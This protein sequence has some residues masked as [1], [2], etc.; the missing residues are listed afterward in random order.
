MDPTWGQAKGG[1]LG[2]LVTSTQPLEGLKVQRGEVLPASFESCSMTPINSGSS[3]TD[4]FKFM[5][6]MV[7]D[8]LPA[9]LVLGG[10]RSSHTLALQ[11]VRTLCFWKWGFAR[12]WERLSFPSTQQ[13][14]P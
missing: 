2:G 7:E 12:D 11:V 14:S 1:A 5:E 13:S 10:G 3:S 6:T 8:T 9:T 4:S